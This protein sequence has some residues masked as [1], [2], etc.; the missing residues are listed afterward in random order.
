MR[1]PRHMA[2]TASDGQAVA[3]VGE[4]VRQVRRISMATATIGWSRLRVTRQ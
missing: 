1:V 2:S 3:Q 4:Q